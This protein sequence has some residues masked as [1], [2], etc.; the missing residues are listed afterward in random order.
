MMGPVE[1]HRYGGKF[2]ACKPHTVS[3]RLYIRVVS[4]G[5]SRAAAVKKSPVTNDGRRV[6]NEPEPSEWAG[7]FAEASDHFCKSLLGAFWHYE[8]ALREN[9]LAALQA[10]FVPGTATIRADDCQVLVGSE[11]INAYRV[12]RVPPPPRAVRRLHVNRIDDMTATIVAESL[13]ADQRRGVQTQVWTHSAAGWQIRSAH[14]ASLAAPT[15]LIPVAAQ[16]GLIWRVL[17]TTP[18]ARQQGP[19]SGLRIAVKDL[20][21]VAGERIGAG[22]PTWLAAARPEP[23][24]APALARLLAAG[25]QLAG[26]AHTDELAFSIAGTNAHY[27]TP[28]NAAAPGRVTGGS[29]SGPAAAVAAGMAEIGLGT[30]T[31]GSIRV[32]ASYCGLY[33]WRPT[34]GAVPQGRVVPLARSFDTVGLLADSAHILAEGARV[35]LAT[36]MNRD[37]AH[38]FVTQIVVAE[39]LLNLVDLPMRIAFIAATRALVGSSRATLRVERQL[40]QGE[41]ETWFSAFRII[42]ACEA[43]MEHGRFVTENPGALDPTVEG[44]FRAGSTVSPLQVQQAQKV[45]EGA[46]IRLDSLLPAG[47]A[48]ALPA[49]STVAPLVKSAPGVEQRIRDDTLRLTFLA[50]AS[51]RPAVVIPTVRVGALPAGLCIVG[52]RGED[53][54]LLDLALSSQPTRG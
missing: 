11:A 37:H 26:I 34:L 30:D 39:D 53:V 3:N 7:V 54:A 45:L 4:L 15:P 33:G 48:L 18:K 47:T 17:T 2:D 23:L 12:G 5:V 27:G 21:A 22:N 43:W 32:P 13:R 51:G 49:T 52:S 20:I 40:C 8:L 41:L 28:A 25:A 6:M 10:A 31:A 44:R 46:G 16:V 42:Q 14:V 24:D 9:D 35:L 36:D 29:S 38:T 1:H 19:L 50:S